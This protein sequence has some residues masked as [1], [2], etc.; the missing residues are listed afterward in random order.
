SLLVSVLVLGVLLGRCVGWSHRCVVPGDYLTIY[1]L[2]YYSHPVRDCRGLASGRTRGVLMSTDTSQDQS[3][4][5]PAIVTIE[6]PS[7]GDRSYLVQ[8][9]QVAAVIDPQRD[10]D[11][12]LDVADQA[13]VQITHVFETHIHND[14][15][16]G[17]VALM[18]AT[19]AS[20][21]VNGADEVSFTRTPISDN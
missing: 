17:G 5:V 11:R 18:E 21:H 1:P 6:T 14:Y 13:G 3:E 7:L 10:I 2:G 9:G 19:G 20:Y 4:A 12:V 15:V 8:D 16:T